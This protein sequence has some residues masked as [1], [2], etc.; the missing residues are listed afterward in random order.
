TFIK[1][2]SLNT[3]TLFKRQ[4]DL[5][6]KLEPYE[7]RITEE[8]ISILISQ[9]LENAF[10][11]SNPGTKVEVIGKKMNAVY[12]ISVKD[13][14]SGMTKDEITKIFALQQ[15]KRNMFNQSGN[16]LGL[17]IAKKI[18]SYINS[19]LDIISNPGE[20]TTVSLELKGK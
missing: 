5:K 11:Y 13:N 2:S 4:N 18:S 9:I 19:N 17:A 3:A 8:S 1:L 12:L 14:G 7:C 20:G 15:F 6:I 10:K 16:G